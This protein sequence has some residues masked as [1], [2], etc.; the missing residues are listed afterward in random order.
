MFSCSCSRTVTSCASQLTQTAHHAL[1]LPYNIFGL[2]MSPNFLDY[3]T[4]NVTNASSVSH[5]KSWPQII[6]NSQLYVIPHPANSPWHWEAKLFI[7]PSRSITLT[8][9]SLV[10]MCVLFFYLHT[11]QA[12]NVKLICNFWND[13]FIFRNM[14]FV[15]R[16]NPTTSLERTKSWPA[17]KTG[18]G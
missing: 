15:W 9:I 17:G 1:Q 6:P 8:G 7:T 13:S 12:S 4:V 11:Y 5:G 2:G 16:Y 3:M 14:L 10:G 18:R